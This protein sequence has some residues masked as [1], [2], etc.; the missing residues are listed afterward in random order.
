MKPRHFI[1][2]LLFLGQN[3]LTQS[4]RIV[5]VNNHDNKIPHCLNFECM[6][7]LTDINEVDQV[8]IINIRLAWLNNL[9]NFRPLQKIMSLI[10]YIAFY[11]S[12]WRW[13]SVHIRF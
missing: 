12:R 10:C 2:S 11:G 13:C 6:K 1:L 5:P 8:I 9:A 3:I 4:Q 7:T